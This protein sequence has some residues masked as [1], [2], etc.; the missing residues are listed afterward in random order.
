MFREWC[1]RIPVID[2]AGERVTATDIERNLW[3]LVNDVHA[4]EVQGEVVTPIGR[5][6][7]DDRDRWAKVSDSL[8]VNDLEN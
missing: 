4:R 3:G 6:T 7:A 8:H 1:Y 2:S 5:L